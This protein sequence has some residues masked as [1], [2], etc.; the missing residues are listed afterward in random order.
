M[1]GKKED[2][3]KVLIQIGCKKDQAC[4]D[5]EK[6]IPYP[7]KF[8]QMDKEYGEIEASLKGQ[9]NNEARNKA[10]EAY[11]KKYGQTDTYPKDGFNSGGHVWCNQNWGTKWNVDNNV[12]INKQIIS[13]DTAW[14]PPLPVIEALAK[15]HPKVK[16]QLKYYEGG[17]GFK[18]ITEYADG[19]LTYEEE[20]EYSGTR[21]G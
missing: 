7:E 14:T 17:M 20:T 6:V 19:E 13:F 12:E 3:A 8:K 4:F 15:Q 2:I 21:G 9:Y 10:F 5:F 1:S 11:K 18:G 16:F